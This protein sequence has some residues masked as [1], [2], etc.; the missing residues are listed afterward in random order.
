[1]SRPLLPGDFVYFRGRYYLI[2]FISENLIL[3]SPSQNSSSVL[4]I[5]RKD[6]RWSFEQ[7]P[8]DHNIQ[9]LAKEQMFSPFLELPDDLLKLIAQN[10]SLPSLFALCKTNTQL[11]NL[12]CNNSAFWSQKYILTYG[13]PQEEILN[14]KQ[15]FQQTKFIR[16]NLPILIKGGQVFHGYSGTFKGMGRE[17][18]PSE[19]D[20]YTRLGARTEEDD[21]D[22]DVIYVTITSKFIRNINKMLMKNVPFE[23]VIVKYIEDTW[24]VKPQDEWYNE[25]G[26]ELRLPLMSNYPYISVVDPYMEVHI[27]ARDKGSPITLYDILFATR[28]LMKD[29]FRVI[30]GYKV[31]SMDN[32]T[33]TLE[34]DIDNFS[35]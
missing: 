13:M 7:F 14:W 23:Q 32:T 12:L 33:L 28:A 9:F 22:E 35:D 3:V 17:I 8:N 30:D 16:E 20:W 21:Y 11:N 10:L 6:S 26:I 29:G 18:T 25:K 19:V 27:S 2:K 15:F 1:M 24:Y 34:P 31:I 4:R 5:T